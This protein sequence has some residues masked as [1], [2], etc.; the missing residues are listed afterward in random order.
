MGMWEDKLRVLKVSIGR[1]ETG[2][3]IWKE[4]NFWSSVIKKSCAWQPRGF[5][6]KSKGKY[7]KA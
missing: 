3:R 4:E 5:N 1:M 2:R 6:R 7:L